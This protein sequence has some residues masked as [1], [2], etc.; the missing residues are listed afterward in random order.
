MSAPLDTTAELLRTARA[1]VDAV[2]FD[3]AGAMVGGEWHGGNGG[4]LS[5]DTI[6]KADACRMA[7]SAYEKAGRAA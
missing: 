7:I 6:Q 2:T 4:L 5:N 3:D 1:L